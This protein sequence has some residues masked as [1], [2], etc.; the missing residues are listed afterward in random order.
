MARL[1]PDDH[2][3]RASRAVLLPG[4][5]SDQRFLDGA[6][7]APLAAFGIALAVP[8]RGLQHQAALDAALADAD[9]PLLVGGVS[10][11]AHVAV[12]WAA[13]LT[14]PA[15]GRL[16]GLLLVMP[17]WT[18]DPDTAPAALAAAGTARTLRAG[19]LPAAI[20]EARCGAPGWLADELARAWTAAGA[21]LADELAGAAARRGPGLPALRR[22]PAPAGVVGLTDDPLHPC[23]VAVQWAAALPSAALV[24]T[25]LLALGRDRASLGRA[26]VLGWLR[27]GGR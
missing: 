1:V 17:A 22:V 14:G 16:R 8:P 11:G 21:G 2:I 12:D 19:G 23:Q 5:G 4:A 9:G 10:L 3:E 24:S 15:A 20:A 26:A 13:R 27:A 18:D 6:F 7:R 25:T